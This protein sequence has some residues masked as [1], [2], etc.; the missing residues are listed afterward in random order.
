MPLPTP[1]LDDR[2]FAE[3]VATLRDQIPGYSR[4]WTDFNPS[5]AG[6]MV[7]ELWCWLVEMILYRMNQIPPRSE[8]NFFKLI[9]DPPEPVTAEV[10]L[11]LSP[12]TMPLTIPA[13]TGFAT[14]VFSSLE[15]PPEDESVLE[16]GRLIFE[17]YRPV[18]LS[19]DA[20]SSPPDLSPVA[21]ASPPEVQVSFSVRSRVVVEDEELGR[22]T[23]RPDQIF[24]LK[25]GPVLLDASN[26]G[27]GPRI[28]NPNPRIRVGNM[29]VLSS[30]PD[31]SPVALASPPE[32]AEVWEYVPDL[33]DARPDAKQFMV[34]QLTGG[35]R[36]GNGA[37]L[38][39]IGLTF[40]NDL[41]TNA[42]VS[43]SLR[44]EFFSNGI[45]LALNSVVSKEDGQWLIDDAE[46]KE[47]YVVVKDSTELHVYGGRGQV[48]PARSQIF[49]ERY[50]IIL[51]KE[52]KIDR[53]MLT[54]LADPDPIPG[55]PSGDI[56]DIA[57]TPAEGGVNI[58]TREEASSR[59]LASLR[60][61]FRTITATDFEEVASTQ[62]NRAQESSLVPKEPFKRVARAVAVPGKNLKGPQPFTDEPA[63]VS[64]IIL[65]EP[66]NP[67]EVQLR[68]TKELTD[69]VEHF[70]EQRRLITTR[71]HV[72]GPEYVSVS[73]NIVVVAEPRTEAQQ[74]RNNI[75]ERLRAFFHPLTG[76][77]LGNGW[78]IGRHVYKSE[79]FQLIEAAAG[80]D[81]VNTIVMNGDPLVN[82]I[83]LAEHESP[84]IDTI[85]IAL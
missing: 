40:Q 15:S 62:Y 50:Q 9:L 59:G 77:A 13:G 72:V 11:T 76:G 79:L 68:P 19:A 84:F 63:T 49:A 75:T 74:V 23:G 5:D 12:Q 64:V 18:S 48:P 7:L 30:P 53:D 22:S 43:A 81:H 71:V 55:L 38:F 67:Q 21:L 35:V 29:V 44:D 57:N 69:K 85:T 45:S 33:I 42:T 27:R 16:D 36:F 34:E 61:T 31:L 28:Y 1:S 65:P 3:L 41:D 82:A 39:R 52:V 56:L 47:K 58:Y 24:Y 37:L 6:I 20:L 8:T 17:T 51:G 60:E 2:S 10:T 25:R 78:P 14:R 32:I 70:L 80:V 73:L 54:E 46:H 66:R 4:A 83:T 26:L